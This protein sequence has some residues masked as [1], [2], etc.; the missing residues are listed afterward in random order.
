LK[1]KNKILIFG[2]CYIIIAIFVFLMLSQ[3]QYEKYTNQMNIVIAEIVDKIVEKYPDV[4]E[5]EIIKILNGTEQSQK[6]Y[7]LEKY[8]YTQNTVAIEEIS[9]ERSSFI[10]IDLAIIIAGG[11]A[12][13]IVLLSYNKKREEKISDINSYI[14]KVNSG[15][16]ELKIEENGEDELTKLRNELYK[17]TVLLRET[18]ENSEKE[19]TNLSNS[20]TDISHQLK[21]P[22]T[23]IRIMIDNIQNNPDMDE[24]TRNEFIEDISKQ[25]DWIS[26][27]VIS[28]LKLAKFDAGSIVMGDEEINVKKLIQNIISNLAILID[29]KDIKIEENISEQITLFAD[30]NWQLEAL[31]NIIKNCVEH[32]FDGGKIKIEAESNSVFTKI[33]I[34]D[35][36]EGI[37][38]KDLNR[39]FERFYKSAKSSENSIGIGLAL[40]KTIIEKERGYI[41][42]ESEVGKGTKFEIKY[43]K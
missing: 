37:E 39:I 1:E 40:A 13:T 29:I 36:G 42:V 41:K 22:L 6:K 19:K 4:E 35:E 31:T 24:K 33:I 11:I 20:L 38:K 25:I 27:L 32:S 23:S 12:V 14:G 3:I 17:T 7:I 8:G 28:L 16:Y 2:I 34:T 30:Y 10:K 26:S 15:N 9:K 18:A 43:L 5:E 21:T